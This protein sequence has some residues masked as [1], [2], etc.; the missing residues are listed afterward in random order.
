MT[1]SGIHYTYW[2]MLCMVIIRD[3]SFESDENKKGDP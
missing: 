1:P 3:A 2:S